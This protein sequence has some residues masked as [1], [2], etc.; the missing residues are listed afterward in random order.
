MVFHFR[1]VGFA[2]DD[3]F[4][5]ETGSFEIALDRMRRKEIEIH[6]DGAAPQCV[7]L[8]RAD[9]RWIRNA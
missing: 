3:F 2:L 9:K 1:R 4:D 5:H 7:G 8:Q 6:G